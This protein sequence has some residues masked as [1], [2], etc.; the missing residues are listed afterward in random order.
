MWPADRFAEVARYLLETYPNQHIVLTGA[1]NEM[2]YADAFLAYIPESERVLNLTGKLSIAE[3]IYVLSKAD[4][5]I[6]NE[7]GI[8]HLAASTNT[9]TIVISQGKSLV[10][11]HPY[12]PPLQGRIVHLYPEYIEQNRNN[13]SAIAP[14]FNPESLFPITIIEPDRAIR[15]LNVFLKRGV[16]FQ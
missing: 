10:R 15:Q 5:L 1:S 3:L 12:L 8:V 9:P 14:K 13:L 2:S 6:A 11:W 4:V 7:T 16:S